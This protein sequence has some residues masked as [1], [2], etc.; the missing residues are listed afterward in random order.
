VRVAK[1]ELEVFVQRRIVLEGVGRV[2]N[3]RVG[4]LARVLSAESQQKQVIEE[5]I[6]D[7]TAGSLQ[8]T[9]ELI[10][11]TKALGL[12]PEACNITRRE[13]DPIFK[14][15]NEIIHDLDMNLSGRQ[16]KRNLRRQGDMVKHANT[17]LGIAQALLLGVSDAVNPPASSTRQ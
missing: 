14:V 17:V 16:R 4:L 13:V 10:R 12:E 11:T 5:Y 9:E 15:R 3:E 7:L 1:K 2:A 8:A 6:D